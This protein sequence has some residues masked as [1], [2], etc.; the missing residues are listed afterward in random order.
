MFSVS[1]D[2]LMHAG[3]LGL[4][5]R[6]GATSVGGSGLG[7]SRGTPARQARGCVLQAKEA[8]DQ[9]SSRRM[10][11]VSEDGL[12]HAASLGLL[13]RV[14]ATSVGGSGLGT[15]VAPL[16]ARRAVELQP[17]KAAGACFRCLK[18]V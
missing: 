5:G 8:S 14:G 9:Q 1:E 10:L 12:T 2:G 11:S 7:Y 6:V 17:S 4:L 13:G 18:M 16:R 3:S 15:H